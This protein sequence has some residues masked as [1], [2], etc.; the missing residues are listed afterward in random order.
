M[1]KKLSK[2]PIYY[3][4][5]QVR[6]NALL[7]LEQFVPAIQESLRQADYPDFERMVA[8][9]VAVNMSPGQQNSIVPA[10]Q[11][12]VRFQFLNARRTAGFN[13]EPDGLVFHTTEYDTFE[14]FSKAFFLGL[15][16]V[17]DAAKLSFSSRL[18]IR[19]LDV[20]RPLRDGETLPEYLAPS[21]MGIFDKLSPRRLQQAMSETRTTRD[22]TTLVS[23]TILL[24]Q[25]EPSGPAM[26]EE[27]HPIV[28]GLPK[29]FDG[30]K[31]LYAIIDTDSFEEKREDFSFDYLEKT[32]KSLHDE[33]AKSFAHTVTDHAREVW[34]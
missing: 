20:V 2:A 19:Y 12:Q 21:V 4:L 29:R 11:T 8:H 3:A 25:A 18:G 16:T 5:A 34:K 26:P 14:T 13:L 33:L 15:K 24:D 17:H 30:I 1:G 32:L 22:Q 23:R 27:L 6:F 9:G 28:L 31:G 7:Q 10:I